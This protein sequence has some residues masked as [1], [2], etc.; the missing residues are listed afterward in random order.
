MNIEELELL[1]E[2][3]D[4]LRSDGIRFNE[5]DVV[6]MCD[7]RMDRIQDMIIDLKEN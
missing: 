7:D 2:S 3:Q 1:Y 6:R 4:K 5:P